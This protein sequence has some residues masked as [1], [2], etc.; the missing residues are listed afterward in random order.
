[1]E[2]MC[3]AHHKAMKFLQDMKTKYTIMYNDFTVGYGL[4]QEQKRQKELEEQQRLG[5][6]PEDEVEEVAPEPIFDGT[7]TE[8]Q[9][10]YM[11]KLDRCRKLAD[12]F[13]YLNDT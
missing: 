7:K 3:A 12:K 11:A 1:M 8:H 2:V 9:L 6:D 10:L 5:E 13:N 4:I